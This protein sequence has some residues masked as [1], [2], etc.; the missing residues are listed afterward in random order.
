MTRFFIAAL[1]FLI[2]QN[3][4]RVKVSLV[5]VGVRVTDSRGRDVRGLQARDFSV[6]DDGQPQT[7]EFFSSEAQPITLGILMD[8]SSSMAYKDKFQ[9]AKDSARAL[10]RTAYDGSEFFYVAFDEYVKL[11][12]D[13]TTDGQHVQ[14]AVEKTELGGGTSL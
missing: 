9:R 10:I 13:F 14:S 5:T 1:L 11:M 6:F 3:I 8:R 7:I 12:A 4:L 2:P